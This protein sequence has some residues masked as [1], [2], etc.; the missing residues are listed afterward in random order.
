M[1]EYEN[2]RQIEDLLE[3]RV[4][5]H[6]YAFSTNTLPRYLKVGDTFRPVDKR[7]EEWLKKI[8]KLSPVPVS[9]KK[10]DS[11]S[12]LI[13]D[14]NSMSVYF[15]D[16]AVHKFLREKLGKENL[17]DKEL[18]K[19]YSQEFF[20]DASVEDVY[21]AIEE[22]KRD[23]ASKNPEKEYDYYSIETGANKEYHG[24]NDK[25]W[26]LRPNQ[27]AVV[28]KF[29]EKYKN[30]D[31]LLMYAVM[32]FGKSFTAMN[33][34]LTANAT[35]VLIVS[36]KADVLG[37]WKKT[38]ETP[39]CFKDFSFLYDK[40]FI[41][42]KDI[43]SKTL[44]QP[45]KNK[46]AVFMTL[47]NLVGKDKDGNNIKAKLKKLYETE[48][49][50]IIVDETHYGAWANTLKRPIAEEDEDVVAETIKENEKF[51]EELGKIKG[52]LRLHLS[53]TPYNLL[54]DEKFTEDNII[55]TCQFSD[56]LQQKAEWDITHFDDIENEVINPE[57]GLP[58]QEYDNPYFGFPKML[59]FA[60]NLNKKAQEALAAA[61]KNGKKWS[62]T[63]L[64][65]T[66]EV[67]G[68]AVFVHEAAVLELLK[69]I[70]GS[71]YDES[72]LSFL[73]I[74]K[75][76]DNDICKHL[77]FVL[78][79]KSSC[80]AM[81]RLLTENKFINLPKN[82]LNITGHTLKPE[83]N[84]VDKVKEKI[85][86]L[87]E[88]SEK[89]ITLTVQKMLTGVTVKE[90]DT[91]IMLRNTKSAQEYDQAV[92][93]IQNQYI[94]EF[95]A[96]D[97]KIIKKD[98]KPQTILVDFDPMRLFELQGLSTRIVN[99]ICAGQRETL[100]EAI[101]NELKFFPIITYNG[102]NLVQV[103]P[104]NIVEI[105][106]RYNKNKSIVEEA[107][108]L[109]LDKRLLDDD[110]LKQFISAQSTLSLSNALTTEAHR[111]KK[112][113]FDHKKLD[114]DEEK[115]DGSAQGGVASSS[116]SGT[117]NNT[118]IDFK[119][120]QSK[121]RKCMANIQFYAFLTGS[122]VDTLSDILKSLYI[123]DE[124]LRNKNRRIFDNLRL[125]LDFIKGVISL[126]SRVSLFEIDEK[127]KNANLLSKDI[128]L[129]PEQRAQNALARLSKISESE[130]VTPTNICMKMLNAIG[131][132][133][134]VEIVNNN[135]RIL[136]ISSKTGEFTFALYSLLKDK[137]DLDKL[138]KSLYAIATSSVTYEFTRR[139]YE[140]LE[141]PLEN[142]AD[143]SVNENVLE[144]SAYNLLKKTTTQGDID[145]EKI[146]GILMQNKSFNTITLNDEPSEGE[147][148]VKFEVVVGNPPY[149][150]E[151]KKDS[152][153]NG[154]KPRTN[155]FHHFQIQAE[156]LATNCT[157]LIFPGA[158]WIHQAGKGLK[159]FGKTLINSTQ[160]SKIILYP[161]S[162]DVFDSSDIPD[163][164]SIVYTEK[165]KKQKGFDYEYIKDG[166][167]ISL[168]QDNPGD[169]LLLI[170]PGDATIAKKIKNYIKEH[171]FKFLHDS[172]LSR[173][174][175]GI[176]SDFIEK[177]KTHAKKY[178]PNVS[179]L[180]DE[181]K[182]LTNDKAGP[183]GRSCW[184]VIKKDLIMS[185]VSFI[186]EWQVVVS[187]AHP[188]GQE[189]RD[190]QLAIIDNR[191]AFGRARVA[192]KSFKTENEAK[193]FFKYLQCPFIKYAFLLSD[194]ALS[195]L[196]KFV[197]DILDYSNENGILDFSKSVKD[198]NNQLYQQY[199]LTK[200][201][202]S[203]I[204]S[205]IK[206]ME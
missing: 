162:K 95:V 113:D 76:K 2:I 44:A 14:S 151:T 142:L 7:I 170:N 119:N 60:F 112:S 5:P 164:I 188:G 61:T 38:I 202:I 169:D 138:K 36:A 11:W 154:Q 8:N 114:E 179:L 130:V 45:Q 75:I 165:T 80:D 82:V 9:L 18:I 139:M 35:K 77:V 71:E 184:F 198:I 201:E 96:S 57:T 64:F 129:P 40:N 153:N 59:R 106:T 3:I 197:P 136:D 23:C 140:I 10:E 48:F 58:Y 116:T 195:S 150:S 131:V 146:Y 145:Y 122:T 16:Y 30:H 37:E 203:F 205:M 178:D 128:D 196:A 87:E 194:E 175:F 55:A 99:N 67:D 91:M 199:G 174:L 97:G 172:I 81:E 177:N 69:I 181:I 187:S 159:Q 93:R 43:I 24:R 50:I 94:Q 1:A 85:R 185:N 70:D 118:D 192:L 124:R 115:K 31:R 182:I 141:L 121:F 152:E 100:N 137:V 143:S 98:M 29:E 102:K 53:G 163:G 132:D 125:D 166:Q 34:A 46:V 20:Q 73:D 158:R 32:R 62:L 109:N 78:P 65:I 107:D 66:R 206:P 52:K 103:E 111:G 27:E 180:N 88:L 160:L 133:K 41:E 63:D 21:T 105:I 92:F 54:K 123:K 157:A 176:E 161:N 89:S 127:I 144:L 15:R 110:Y 42:D 190:N 79:F 101:E 33:C 168:K 117:D 120:L 12:S 134:L 148:K 39:T 90:W 173:S 126:S 51:I 135:G 17:T 28:K 155:I 171:S 84:T 200:E 74:P 189:G 68:K 183:A 49:D 19:I 83:L 204:E 193:N 186:D 156:K 147:E 108:S 56:I 13:Q 6:I 26:I 47:Q 149:Q 4:N 22:I 191:S 25:E 167:S 104:N 86:K 72:I